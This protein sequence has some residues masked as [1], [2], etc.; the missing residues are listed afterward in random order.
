MTKIN[1]T[2]ALTDYAGDEKQSYQSI[3]QKYQVSKRSVVKQAVKN[4]WQLV[5]QETALKVH[6][7]LPKRLSLSLADVV[8]RQVYVARVMQAKALEVLLGAKLQPKNIKEV[9]I[10]LQTG[11]DIERKALGLDVV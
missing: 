10:C 3:A 5:R 4:N 9:V 2:Q 1:W 6:Q 7:E 8:A 11:I